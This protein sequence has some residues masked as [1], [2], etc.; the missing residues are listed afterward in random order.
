MS[1][2]HHRSNPA[3]GK[4]SSSVRENQLGFLFDPVPDRVKPY[5]RRFVDKKHGKLRRR[6]IPL[7]ALVLAFCLRQRNHRRNGCQ[8]SSSGWRCTKK[9][10]AD[11]LGY[12]E[13]HIRR[14]FKRLAAVKLMVRKKVDFQDP[15]DPWNHACFRFK[16]TFLQWQCVD[17]IKNRPKTR[18]LRGGGERAGRRLARLKEAKWTLD[19]LMVL[20]TMPDRIVAEHLDKSRNSV[21]I[22]RRA[23]GLDVV[24]LRNWDGKPRPQLVARDELQARWDTFRNETKERARVAR[25]KMMSS[26][27]NR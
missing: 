27:P 19:Q 23:L 5:L 20:G 18:H 22:M 16:F 24:D 3:K 2:L 8:D 1:N 15:D 13:G 12:S 7:D 4:C 10:I 9:K 11:A 17:E 6:L 25:Q 26:L 14:S 21:A